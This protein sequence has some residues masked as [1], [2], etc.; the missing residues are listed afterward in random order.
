YSTI[1]NISNARPDGIF[2]LAWSTN[3]G[4]AELN[5]TADISTNLA[6]TICLLDHLAKTRSVPIV[7]V[8][9]GGTVY[10]PTSPDPICETHPLNPVSIY[11]MTKCAMELY[12]QQCALLSALDI[13]IA[14][15]SNPFGAGQAPAKM[16]GAATIFARR[17]IRGEKIEIW[18]KG[19][20]V[21]DYVDV[22]DVASGL[23]SIMALPKAAHVQD[24][25]FNIGSG[26]GLS[27]LDLIGKLEIATDRKADIAFAEGRGFDIPVNILNVDKLSNATGWV[28]Q[29]IDKRLSVL[30]DTLLKEVR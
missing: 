6:G 1:Y 11:G 19:D 9:S 13:R 4:T 30:V 8:S 17:I 15:V 12:A 24:Q 2:H 22:E 29:N 18:G 7:L 23:A 21:R 5:P 10:G 14:R 16:Q 25:I 20:V 26:R 3:P 28:P 27:L